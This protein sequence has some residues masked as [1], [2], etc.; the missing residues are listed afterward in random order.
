VNRSLSRREEGEKMKKK[1]KRKKIN[2]QTKL[3]GE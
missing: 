3:T 2:K 1:T